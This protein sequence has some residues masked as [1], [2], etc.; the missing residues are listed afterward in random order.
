MFRER[1]SEG[2]GVGEKHQSVA[3]VPSTGDLAHTQ[4]CALTGNR[5]SYPLVCMLALNPLSHTSQGF[6]F[7]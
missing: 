6:N 1:G 2:E 7:F 4:A 3:P 5:T